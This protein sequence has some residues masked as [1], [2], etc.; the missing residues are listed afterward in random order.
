M[1]NEKIDFIEELSINENI[2]INYFGKETINKLFLHKLKDFYENYPLFYPCHT[3]Y[4][5]F[6]NF[7]EKSG[8]KKLPTI[9]NI[10]WNFLQTDMGYGMEIA[11]FEMPP[12]AQ[13]VIDKYW[14]KECEIG[15]RRHLNKY[16]FFS[17][18]GFCIKLQEILGREIYTQ[19]GLRLKTKWRYYDIS[20]Y[21]GSLRFSWGLK[22]EVVVKKCKYCGEEFIPIFDLFEWINRIEEFHPPIKSINDIDFCRYHILPYYLEIRT[23]PINEFHYNDVSNRIRLLKN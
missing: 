5:S 20:M 15:Y 17:Y 10:F 19:F 8:Y 1:D 14:T 9:E 11:P 4:P 7:L 13:K 22:P 16:G 18:N 12:T 2:I 23:A 21:L 6:T 3:I